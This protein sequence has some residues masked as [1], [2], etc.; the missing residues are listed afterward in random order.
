[1]Y[2]TGFS[3]DNLSNMCIFLLYGLSQPNANFRSGVSEIRIAAKRAGGVR[4]LYIKLVALHFRNEHTKCKLFRPLCQTAIR[5]WYRD[6]P[7][8]KEKD[9]MVTKSRFQK[10]PNICASEY[11]LYLPSKV[12]LKQKLIDWTKEQE[13]R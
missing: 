1:M 2:G 10:S 6:N 11:Q 4:T 7:L 5:E 3:E 13:V 9:A 12:E 8:S